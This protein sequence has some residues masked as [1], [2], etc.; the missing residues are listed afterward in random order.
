M[1]ESQLSGEQVVAKGG[2]SADATSALH[3]L[4]VLP[5]RKT[6]EPEQ[7]LDQQKNGSKMGKMIHWG[8]TDMVT[9]IIG[10]QYETRTENNVLAKGN[11]QEKQT[12][13]GIINL[14]LNMPK[15]SQDD[16]MLDLGKSIYSVKPSDENHP[17]HVDLL[18][19]AIGKFQSSVWKL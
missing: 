13:P 8:D 9:M 4:E 5:S 17:S 12:T 15:G 19:K 7:I 14:V 6:S 18:G 16:I 3:N 11:I 10:D 1:V 2:G